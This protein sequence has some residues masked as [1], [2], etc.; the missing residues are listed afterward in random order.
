MLWIM[1]PHFPA[2][3]GTREI[4]SKRK[5]KRG[6]EEFLKG[7]CNQGQNMPSCFLACFNKDCCERLTHIA[8]QIYKRCLT[9]TICC[10]INVLNCH[11]LDTN[12][13]IWSAIQET[14]CLKWSLSAS[15]FL[16]T[17]LCSLRTGSSEC[18]VPIACI[19]KW[20][21]ECGWMSVAS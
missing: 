20:D 11:V 14:S 10:S 17:N 2:G 18:I 1:L 21:Q 15:L 4:G 13:L 8:H 16:C 12:S 6:K 5:G 9:V 3:K 19:L 7:K